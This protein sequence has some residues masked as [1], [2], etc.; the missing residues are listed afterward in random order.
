MVP[1][2]GD[3]ELWP[4]PELILFLEDHKGKYQLRY[5]DVTGAHWIDFDD[6][7]TAVICRLTFA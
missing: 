6:K 4:S 5:D 7:G 2:Q 3:Y 1:F